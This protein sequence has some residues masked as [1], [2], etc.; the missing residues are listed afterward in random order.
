[1]QS[2][3]FQF[4]DLKKNYSN[5]RVNEFVL[6]NRELE[7]IKQVGDHF[8]QLYEPVFLY[9]TSKFGR[10]QFYAPA[11]QIGNTRIDTLWFNIVAIWFMI[12][13]LYIALWRNYLQR[14]INL[15]ENRKFRRIDR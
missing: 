10:A 7:R 11:K 6:N 15:I 3:V 12:L 9:P 14:F 4:L 8:I 1:M 13:V 2:H 5:Q